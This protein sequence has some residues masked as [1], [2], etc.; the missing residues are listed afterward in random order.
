MKQVSPPTASRSRH[1]LKYPMEGNWIRRPRIPLDLPSYRG[2]ILHL[3]VIGWVCS[4]FGRGSRLRPANRRDTCSELS[5][6]RIRAPR[7]LLEYRRVLDFPFVFPILLFASS[8][9]GQHLI[10][11]TRLQR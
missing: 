2:G 1:N 3:S 8:R 11:N 10:G 4:V 9:H 7:P 5:S 6:V